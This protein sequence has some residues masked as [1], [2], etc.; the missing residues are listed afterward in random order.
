MSPRALVR[1][2]SPRL[3]D[4]LVTH[5]QKSV[6]DQDLAERQWHDYVRALAD[7]G[8]APVEVDRADDNPDG[9][10]IEDAVVVYGDLAVI[11]RAGAIQRRG[12]AATARVAAEA[13]GLRIAEITEPGTLDGGDVLKVGPTVYVGLTLRTNQAAVDQLRELLQPAGFTVVAVPTTKVLHL[14]SAVTALPDGTV[15]GYP[16]LVDD[17]AFFGSS[18]PSPRKPAR[19]S[20]CSA[21]TDC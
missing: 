5:I 14:K 13:A 7:N 4:G 8:F 12:E 2:P 6:I 18:W 21:T 9:V 10:F 15:I 16:P 19:T 1:F 11:S 17:P 3:S 20:C